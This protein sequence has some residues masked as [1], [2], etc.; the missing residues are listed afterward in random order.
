MGFKKLFSKR[1]YIEKLNR[2]KSQLIKMFTT[3]KQ[4]AICGLRKKLF[5][6][7]DYLEKKTLFTFELLM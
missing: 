4:C 6:K 7:R 1:D 2:F 3:P 5:S